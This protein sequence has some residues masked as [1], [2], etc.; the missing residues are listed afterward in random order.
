MTLLRRLLHALLAC[1]PAVTAGLLALLGVN[2]M[3]AAG[4]VWDPRLEWLA[5]GT[6]GAALVLALLFHQ[7]RLA[8]VAI[9]FAA[10]AWC[11]R[12]GPLEGQS[13]VL[14]ALA[15]PA[16]ALVA[17]LQTDLRSFSAAALLRYAA[18]LLVSGFVALSGAPAFAAW[19]AR[20]GRAAPGLAAWT[21]LPALSLAALALQLATLAAPRRRRTNGFLLQATVMAL[22]AIDGGWRQAL[23]ADARAWS[24][25]FG[26]A[27]GLLLLWTVLDAAWQH[28]F[29]DELTGL[30]GRRPLE[31]H[32]ASLGRRFTLAM[33]DIDHFKRINDRFGHETG[34]QVLRFIAGQLAAFRG[35]RAYRYG[36]EE[37]VIVMSGGHADRHVEALDGL[38]RR[39]GERRFVIRSLDRPKR[40]PLG[41][42]GRTGAG[43][44]VIK[45]TVS[46]GSAAWSDRRRR[47]SEVLEAA[48]KALYRAKR[49]GRNRVC[50]T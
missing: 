20:L 22:V 12:S 6:L 27:T 44:G 39:I 7:A 47:P 40:K 30:P 48:D 25:C 49:G 10:V 34:D 9:V 45:V 8:M 37:F 29:M 36:G 26:G 21:S 4:F 32:L 1:L 46:I 5:P 41:R 3:A 33:V 13:Y 11:H 14:A 43:R 15:M 23:S 38:R 31:H 35:G 18:G 16:T 24:V 42:R 2:R 17:S 19:S 28:A 50:A